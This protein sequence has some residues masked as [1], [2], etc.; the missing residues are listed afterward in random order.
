MY[1][2]QYTDVSILAK[3]TDS[4]TIY[5]Y[6]RDDGFRK[7]INFPVFSINDNYLDKNSSYGYIYISDEYS[8]VKINTDEIK[9]SSLLTST[10]CDLEDFNKMAE[11]FMASRSN[12]RNSFKDAA[13]ALQSAFRETDRYVDLK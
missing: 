5:G 1:P 9:C 2:S 12:G 7:I 4:G 13:N 11:K 3:L 10:I 8:M 6:K